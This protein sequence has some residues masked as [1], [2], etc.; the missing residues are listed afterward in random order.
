LAV[1][2]IGWIGRSYVIT[3]RHVTEY[4]RIGVPGF[5]DAHWRASETLQRL[6]AS[7]PQGVVYSNAPEIAYV[8]LA[9]E[10]RRSPR[11]HLFYARESRVTDLDEFRR[12]LSRE[13]PAT[14]VWFAE[15]G[16]D[17]FVAPPELAAEEIERTADGAL[18][19]VGAP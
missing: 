10:V 16:E 14:L 18:Y 7:P 3:R 19:R 6:R 15:A 12:A 8:A 9:R 2:A 11:A 1:L 17:R 5:G 4:A 13:G